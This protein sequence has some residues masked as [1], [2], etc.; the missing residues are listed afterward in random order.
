MS[1]DPWPEPP[2]LP[3]PVIM[4][5]R[6]TDADFLHWRIP[7]TEAATKM[8]PGVLPDVFDGSSWVGLVAFRLQGGSLGRGPA[9]PYFGGFTEVNVRLYSR[10][11][12]GRRG[13]VFLSLDASRLAVVLAARAVGIPYV[14][15]HARFKPGPGPD[16][17]IGYSVRRFRQGAKTDFAVTPDLNQQT[18]DPLAIHLT[19]R[20]GL[21]TAYAA[22]PFTC[23]TPI[24]LGRYTGPNSPC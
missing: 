2:D 6:W 23:Q 24:P 1:R 5:Q 21:H 17:A 20:F 7:E 10:E 8:P 4:A 18:T 13:V 3:L 11:P 19:A 12:G 14:W 9:V 15:S 16:T 22:A